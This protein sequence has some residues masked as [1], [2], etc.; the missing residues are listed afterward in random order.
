MSISN[1]TDRRVVE[2]SFTADGVA[3]SFEGTVPWQIRDSDGNVV[4]DG[5]AQA[6]GY[7]DRL[8]PWATDRSTCPTST[9]ATTPSS[10]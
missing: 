1:P 9:P 2:D 5:T 7:I 10:P 3:S 4:K 6:F 8:Y